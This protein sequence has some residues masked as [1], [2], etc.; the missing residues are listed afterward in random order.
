MR[1]VLITVDL[2]KDVFELA[3][4][5]EACG[6]AHHWARH[7][8][9]RGFEVTLLPARYVKPYRQ[10]NKTDRADCEA[11]L[12]AFRSPRI[13]PVPIKSGDQQRRSSPCTACASSGRT[14]VPRGSTPSAACSASSGWSHPGAHSASWSGSPSSSSSTGTSCRSASAASSLPSGARPATSRDACGRSSRSWRRSPA[15]TR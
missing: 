8:G 7:L 9:A 2:A 11:L 12:E 6:G 13:A 4:V 1:N 15:R 14:L 3:V 10:R 5:M